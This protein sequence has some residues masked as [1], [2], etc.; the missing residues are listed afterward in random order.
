M[1]RASGRTRV[2]RS[3]LSEWLGWGFQVRAETLIAG[4]AAAALLSA[5]A[6]T[7]QGEKPAA[8]ASASSAPAQPPR[9]L[10]RG[11]DARTNANPFPSTYRPFPSRP[12]AIINAHILTGAGQEIP[13]GTVVMVDGRIAAVGAGVAPP[14]GATIVDAAGRWVTPGLID[15]HSHLG[16]GPSP[17][18]GPSGDVNEATEPNTAEVWAEHGVWPQDPGFNRAREGGVTSMMVLPGSANLFGGRSVTLKNVPS[19]TM[20][21][22]KFP[23]APY[24]LKMACGEN[25]KRVY[26]SR[27]RSPSTR[28]GNVAGYRTGWIS[29][30]EYKRKWERYDEDMARRRNRT[31]SGGS[32]G[33]GGGE[34]GGREPDPPTRNLELDTLSGV[35]DGKILIQNHCYRA[36]EMANMVDISKEF[37]FKIAMFHH[38]TESYKVADMLAREGICSAMWAGWWGFKLES[39]D[40]IEAN[41]PIVHRAGAC[42]VIHSDDEN[43]IQRLNQEA[44]AAMSAGL[45][46]GIPL[47]KAEVI[48]WITLNAAKAIGVGDKTGSLEP[49]KMADVVLWTRDPF[50]V[51]AQAEQVYVDGAL[52]YDRRNPRLQPRSDFEL[53]QPSTAGAPSPG[54]R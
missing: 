7:S 51:Y 49:G 11:L 41:A 46:A 23:D 20:Q 19:T 24:G 26:G 54:A 16:N 8:Q 12:T 38:A 32:G 1:A 40:G 30:A 13:S 47:T 50:S 10:Q 48:S 9:P 39:Y 14:Q 53:G 25:P 31:G 34:G 21:G 35:L 5:C 37:G 4:A 17:S 3:S 2:S 15:A 42:A 28:M 33:S 29:A 27:Q 6:A 45:A 43:I 22:M 52:L 36:D 18:V 44:A